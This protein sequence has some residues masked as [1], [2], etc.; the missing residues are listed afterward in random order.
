MSSEGE[1]RVA[2]ATEFQRTH[3]R[4]QGVS[5]VRRIGP[6]SEVV[7]ET[8]L[9]ALARFAAEKPGQI[10]LD[11]EGRTLTFAE[12]DRQSNRIAHGLAGY[13]VK[14]GDRVI[15][16]ID[17]SDDLVLIFF[18][19]NKLGAIWVPINTAYR[20]PFL[21]HQAFDADAA[22]A[23]CEAHYADQ[24]LDLAAE[25]PALADVFVRG[26]GVSRTGNPRITPFERLRAVEDGPVGIEVTPD[27]L[28]ALIYTSGTTGASKGCMVSHSYLCSIGR[29]RNRCIPPTTDDITWSC[30]PLSHIAALGSLLI[31]NLLAGARIA[32]A[33]HFSVSGFWPEIERSGATHG[34]L[35]ASMFPLLAHAQDN[36][37]M[38]RCRGKLKSVTGVPLSEGDRKIW[39]E[40]FGVP[41][42][43]TF[44]YGQTEAVMVTMRPQGSPQPPVGSMG[45]PTEE[46]E[47]MVAGD[48]NRPV[49]LGETGELCVRP[50][51]PGSMFSG[52]WRRPEDTLKAMRDLWWHTGDFVRMDEEG[53][54]FFVDRKKDYLR[55]RGENISSFEVES[56]LM[57]HP[58]ISEAACFAIAAG[59]GL[60]EHVKAA[61]VL[62]EGG[63]VSERALFEWARDNL[64]YFAVPRYIEL[65]TALPKT[66]TGRVQK[67]ELRA[68]GITVETWDS[69]AEKLEIRRPKRAK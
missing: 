68:K 44:A 51:R 24:L 12:L 45:P 16:L 50:T 64:P 61:I 15:T 25:L 27:D 8:Y 4:P 36:D 7:G 49:P 2:S 40:R 56:A 48:D 22:L 67:H 65:L 60:E 20:G 26:D 18:A 43:M 59:Q 6:P 29:Q 28:S 38:L 31:S 63:G 57:T 41:Y 3:E 23:I 37:A 42:M 39:N 53:Y 55:S 52:Y 46:F 58:A 13:G 5:L 69:V 34:Q 62:A 35:M 66:P 1:S 11:Y 17:N 19:I 14:K 32:I 47:V 30:L 10:F 33:T 21:R 9:D 54:L